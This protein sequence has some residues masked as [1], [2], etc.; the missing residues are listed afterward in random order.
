MSNKK[1]KLL[2]NLMWDYDIPAEKCLDLLLGKIPMVA[3][4]TPE[5]LFKKLLES[6]SWFTVLEIMPAESI[7]QLLSADLIEKLRTPKLR[8]RYDFIRHRISELV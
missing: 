1:L 6:Y 2:S 4:Y 5:S 7:K 3:H 8:S